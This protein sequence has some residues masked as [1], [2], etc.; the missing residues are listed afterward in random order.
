MNLICPECKNEVDLIDFPNL[1]KGDVVECDVCGI[2]LLITNINAEGAVSAEIAD[3][4][5]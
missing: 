4:G 5:K 2:S 3:E 1:K